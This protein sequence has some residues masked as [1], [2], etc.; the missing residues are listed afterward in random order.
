MGE[1]LDV[2][3][4][5]TPNLTPYSGETY[6]RGSLKG[7]GTNDQ[8]FRIRESLKR[9]NGVGR[10]VRRRYAICQRT[11]NVT[12]PNHLWHIDLNHL[13]TH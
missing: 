5:Q 7:W 13:L 4:Q 1:E 6:V 9:I 12:R 10:A 3:R 8:Q 11:Y 2:Q